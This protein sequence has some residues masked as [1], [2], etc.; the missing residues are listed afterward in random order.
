MWV[1]I[2]VG[3]SRKL[4]C[5]AKDIEGCLLVKEHTEVLIGQHV[6]GI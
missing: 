3:Q 1:T 5:F 2:Y 6:E 4:N